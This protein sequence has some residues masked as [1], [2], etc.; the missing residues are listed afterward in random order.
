MHKDTNVTMFVQHNRH[1]F[2]LPEINV[3]A[4]WCWHSVRLAT[5]D[6]AKRS[7]LARIENQQGCELSHYFLQSNPKSLLYPSQ[8]LL[9]SY[10][11]VLLCHR[12]TFKHKPGSGIF[13][14]VYFSAI[15]KVEQ[16]ILVLRLEKMWTKDKI[17]Y[18][19][20]N[21]MWLFYYNKLTVNNDVVGNLKYEQLLL[22]PVEAVTIYYYI[23]KYMLS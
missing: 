4:G 13:P 16:S 21:H 6:D 5:G 12:N 3:C 15:I 17:I 23:W 14:S 8:C 10:T 11:W 20:V 9:C 2:F 19:V 1:R 7:P 22:N 18:K